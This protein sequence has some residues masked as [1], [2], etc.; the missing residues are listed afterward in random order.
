[1]RLACMGILP[2]TLTLLLNLSSVQ[3]SV[4]KVHELSGYEQVGTGDLTWLGMTVYQ[5]SLYAPAGKYQPSLPHALKI[6]Y[7]FSFSAAQLAE[8]SLT[9]IERVHGKQDDRDLLLEQLLAVF[10]DVQRGDAIVGVHYPGRG[11]SF[12]SKGE[13]LG[14]W[15]NAQLAERFFGI[16]LN[17]DTREPRLRS[18]LLGSRQ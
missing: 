6:E 14:R 15:E 11:A 17:A 7:R 1:M 8:R 5:A 3:A 9:E 2:V 4:S 18:Q 12:Y 16:W 13:L 10:S